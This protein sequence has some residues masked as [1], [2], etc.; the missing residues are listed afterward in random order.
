M[1]ICAFAW[2]N[3]CTLTTTVCKSGQSSA[4][5][6]ERAHCCLLRDNAGQP[7]C[8]SVGIPSTC[9]VDR[10]PFCSAGAAPLRNAGRRSTMLLA[11]HHCRVNLRTGGARFNGAGAA[12]ADGAGGAGGAT[13]A[14]GTGGAGG[15][16]GARGP[17]VAEARGAA[18]ARGAGGAT[19]AAGAEGAGVAGAGRAGAAGS[20]P[21]RLLPSST[22][23]T[24]P[25]LRSQTDQ[26]PPQLLLGYS[27]LAPAPHTEVTESLTKHREPETRASASVRAHRITRPRPP[28][29]PN[30][31]DMALRPS[32]VPQRVVLLEPHA[33]SL[34]HIHDP[35]S[36]LA[37]AA[38]TTVTRLL[39]TVVTD[40]DLEST[41]EFV[42]VT[43]LVEVPPT[44]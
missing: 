11:H 14:A 22:G 8:C 27:L 44:L 24:P 3:T 38:S 12:E 31:H 4:R 42:L 15:T 40:P 19:G 9:C 13:G 16:T 18:G 41:A 1:H 6:C 34:P 5:I 17:G 10:L 37:R 30:T 20:G 28:A 33:S 29:V 2:D 35:E 25:L 43:E 21:R 39:A 23:L 7:L 32:S 36:D 26:S